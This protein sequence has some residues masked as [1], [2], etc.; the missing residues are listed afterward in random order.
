MA[1]LIS[2]DDRIGE[3]WDRVV[4]DHRVDDGFVLQATR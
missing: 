3:G 2:A 1:G 4:E